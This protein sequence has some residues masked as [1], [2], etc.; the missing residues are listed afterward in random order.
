VTSEGT[1]L[2]DAT[3]KVQRAAFILAALEGAYDHAE[4]LGDPELLSFI[5]RAATLAASSLLKARNELERVKAA[6]A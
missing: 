6:A 1:P 5:S 2:L 4:P 3:A